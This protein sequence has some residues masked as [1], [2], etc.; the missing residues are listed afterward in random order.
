[1]GK[2]FKFL[3]PLG[4]FIALVALLFFGLGTDP[5]KVP[6]PLVGKPA[7]KFS[8]P[9]LN[10]PGRIVTDADF[11]GQVTLLNVWASWCVSC[12]AEHEELM[13]LSRALQGIQILGLN[14]KDTTADAVRM[15][16]LSG[17]PYVVSAFDPEN[18]VGIDWGVY[19]APETFLV[20]AD[21]IICYKKIGPVGPGTWETEL[22]PRVDLTTK[23]CREST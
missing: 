21:G 6:S 10:E 13:R 3:I 9:A 16:R 14:W 11:R 4:L 12:R 23:K 5:R 1:M 19:G 7:P 18:D 15:L 22:A 20:D 8:L 17:D 2:S